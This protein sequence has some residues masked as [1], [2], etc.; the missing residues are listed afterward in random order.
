M[1]IFYFACDWSRGEG[2]GVTESGIYWILKINP[3]NTLHMPE[4]DGLSL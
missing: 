1:K 3:E 2:V 4:K